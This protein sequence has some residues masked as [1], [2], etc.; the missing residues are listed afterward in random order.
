MATIIELQV[1][2]III[3]TITITRQTVPAVAALIEVP[4]VVALVV[5][6]KDVALE[7]ILTVGNSKN[8]KRHSKRVTIQTFS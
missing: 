2:I 6:V 4:A 5:V 8:W 7:L 3:I 1:I